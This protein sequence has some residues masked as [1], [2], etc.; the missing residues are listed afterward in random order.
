MNPMRAGE[1]VVL[2]AKRGRRDAPGAPVEDRGQQ[3]HRRRAGRGGRAEVAGD[4]VHRAPRHEGE[5]GERRGGPR[6]GERAERRHVG[7]VT[8]GQD[9]RVGSP[10]G[11]DLRSSLE[12]GEGGRDVDLGAAA[13]R[14]GLDR[15]SQSARVAEAA[16]VRV[17]QDFDS[18]GCRHLTY[19]GSTQA[20]YELRLDPDGCRSL[21]RVRD[22][23][24]AR[25][26]LR[27]ARGAGRGHVLGRLRGARRRS[28]R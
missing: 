4:G 2:H 27:G 11:D 7:A 17:E 19:R 9:D 15:A 20:R 28:S 16:R 5:P 26:E 10:S 23:P 13:P 21:R 6:P 12:V 22:P 8:S 1:R 3:A 14:R 18:A 24:R 25:S